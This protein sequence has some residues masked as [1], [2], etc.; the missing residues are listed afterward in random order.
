MPMYLGKPVS[1]DYMQG[2]IGAYRD[3]QKTVDENIEDGDQVIID[4][5]TAAKILAKQA[6]T[7]LG[8]ADAQKAAG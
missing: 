5:L 6:A 4:R 2:S 3:G 1:D 8:T 7:D